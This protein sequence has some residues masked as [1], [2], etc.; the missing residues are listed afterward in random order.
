MLPLS[1]LHLRL[2]LWYLHYT[3]CHERQNRKRHACHV[4]RQPNNHSLY[5][6]VF[7]IVYAAGLALLY[8]TGKRVLRTVENWKEDDSDL[9]S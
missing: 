6:M 7:V 4:H 8:L 3:V 9:I 1:R 2:P 5:I